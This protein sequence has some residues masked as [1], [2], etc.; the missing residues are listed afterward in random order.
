MIRLLCASV[1]LLPCTV[2]DIR[3]RTI[4]VLFV[5]IVSFI[6]GITELLFAFSGLL[7]ILSGLIPGALLFLLSF[8]KKA[9]IGMGDGILIMG[10]GVFCGFGRTVS[11]LLFGCLFAGITGGALAVF[12]KSSLK[13]SLPFA[14]FLM[15]GWILEMVSEV[16][17]HAVS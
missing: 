9:G 3:S 12:R 1:I 17:N 14:P 5:A 10:T 8:H 4:P 11:L 13:L 16:I 15:A 2:T 7:E 6:G